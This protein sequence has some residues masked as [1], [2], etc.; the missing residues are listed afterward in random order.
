M[1]KIT[2]DECRMSKECRSSN[3]ESRIQDSGERRLPACRCRHLAGNT[4]DGYH[5][6]GEIL[7]LGAFW[8]AA[9]NNR[10]AACAPQGFALR[11][12]LHAE[13]KKTPVSTA[14]ITNIASN[15][16]TTEAVVA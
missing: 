1:G 8:H 2:N 5:A 3:D 10:L 6:I 16:C 9:K 4:L 14:F 7:I 12:L 15:A 11:R 13:K